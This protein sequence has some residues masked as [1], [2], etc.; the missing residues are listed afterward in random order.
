MKVLWN[1]TDGAAYWRLKGVGRFAILGGLLL[2][3][4]GALA[5]GVGLLWYRAVLEARAD[6]ADD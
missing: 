4:G 6:P 3:L 5:Y 1:P 2:Q